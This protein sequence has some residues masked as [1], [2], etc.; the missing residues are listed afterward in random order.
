MRWSQRVW[1]RVQA[2]T[3]ALTGRRRPCCKL[4]AVRQGQPMHYCKNVR[5]RA[6]P[7]A[8]KLMHSVIPAA[9]S[10]GGRRSDCKRRRTCDGAA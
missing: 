6:V 3:Q 4:A 10:P 5:W 1:M 2:R 7:S 9:P 8:L